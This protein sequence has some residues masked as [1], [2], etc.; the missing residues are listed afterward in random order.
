MTLIR[1]QPFQELEIRRQMDHIFD[2]INGSN[3]NSSVSWPAI[4][5]QDAN[6]L[7]PVSGR[8]QDFFPPMRGIEP[9][10]SMRRSI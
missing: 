9:D 5:V 10:R 3:R 2:E 7:R 4:E 1:W 6:S 8:D